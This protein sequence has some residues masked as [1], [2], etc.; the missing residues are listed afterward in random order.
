[1]LESN[2]YVILIRHSSDEL[3]LANINKLPIEDR[4]LSIT[5]FYYVS[6]ES[7]KS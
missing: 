4:R 2:L 1:M 7:C 6:N 3:V 5:D